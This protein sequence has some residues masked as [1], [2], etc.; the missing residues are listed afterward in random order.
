MALDFTPGGQYVDGEWR[1]SAGG[2][3]IPV[4]NPTTEETLAEVATA[5]E[6]GVAAAIEAAEDARYDWGKRPAQ[7]RGQLVREV[8]E[9]L[10]DHREELAELV[11]AEQGKPIS[12]ARGEIEGATDMAQ[13][14]AEWDRRIEGDILPGESRE[15]SIHIQRRP[16][17]VVAA[18]APWNYPVAVFMRK[19][20][21]ALVAG[22]TVVAK[23]SEE[24]PLATL[25]LAEL[26]DENVDL[27]DGV[28]NLVTGDG[29]VGAQLVSSP[30]VDMVS[31]TGNVETGK[32]IM[33]DAAAN[34]TKV[35]L[36]LGGKAPAI[37][38]KDADVDQA[39]E[40]VLTART[41]NTGQVCTCAERVYVHT[42][43][44]AEFEEKYVDAAEG[45]EYGDPLT[46]PDMGPQVSGAELDKTERAV[47]S[48]R[49]S[50][51]EV[52]T[53]GQRPTGEAYERGYWY[54]PTV[55]TGVEQGDDV[56][57]QEVFGPVTPIVEIDSLDQAIEYANDSRYGLS[58][59]VYTED[60]RTAMRA[61]EDLEFGETYINRSL[62]EAWHGHHIGWK[63]SGLGGEDGKY[64]FLKY[65]QL[66]TVYHDY[67]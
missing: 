12:D 63:E 39:V 46:D 25:R 28:F 56:I 38:W 23:P 47:E 29:S 20:A 60:Y 17:G 13:Y 26:I 57:Q 58:S 22:N 45:V 2:E 44:R 24:T 37:V 51:A 48:A 64:G 7:E 41:T 30:T 59:Y 8:G 53:G 14:M 3:S 34:L 43:V 42:D 65:T 9:V 10:D 33:A 54:E 16:V 6:A 21:P 4:T 67:S 18:I 15:E 50:G 32:Q 11:V 35:S 31:M 49:E 36:E 5:T 61:A 40:D 66:K 27:P 62:G 55:L 52:L 19:F 1:E